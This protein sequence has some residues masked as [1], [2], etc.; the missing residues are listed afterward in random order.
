[1]SSTS[2]RQ[3]VERLSVAGV[4]VLVVRDFDKAGFSI[5]H[6]L[7]NDTRRFQFKAAP[8]VIDL[9]LRL[10]D[11]REMDLQSET[12]EYDS[13]KNPQD[14]LIESGATQEEADFLVRGDART[15]WRGERVELNA[16]TSPQFIEWL[17]R[18]FAEVGVQ[19]VVPDE[20]VLREAYLRARQQAF[21]QEAVDKARQE[22][23]EMRE[24]VVVP[25]DL[26]EAVTERISGKPVA[27]DTALSEIAREHDEDG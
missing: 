7:C 23:E 27:W 21:I 24:T 9:G 15:R 20:D 18:K 16:M 5:V 10:A 19:K 26:A 13:N 3:L 1:M 25:D 6:T 4:T 11:V 14:N 17:D 8:N 2:A 12:V 22:A